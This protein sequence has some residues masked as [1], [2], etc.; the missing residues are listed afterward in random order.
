MEN[1]GFGLAF[2]IFAHIFEPRR[3][4]VVA[5][6]YNHFV[7]DQKR[8]NLPSFTVGILSPDGSHP[9]VL[10]IEE[11]LFIDFVF[12]SHAFHSFPVF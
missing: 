10:L 4:P 2:F 11:Y 3:S 8:T 9:K 6:G 1:I 12:C 5:I 7:L